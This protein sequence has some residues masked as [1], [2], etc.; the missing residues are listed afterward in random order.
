MPSD[1]GLVGPLLAWYGQILGAHFYAVNGRFMSR[2]HR[3]MCECETRPGGH[4]YGG[5]MGAD[6]TLNH[7]CLLNKDIHLFLS[8][9]NLA[10]QRSS[11]TDVH[12][13]LIFD[14]IFSLTP[15]LSGGRRIK[16]ENVCPWTKSNYAAEVD[17]DNAR[18]TRFDLRS[19][20][21]YRRRR[22]LLL[23]KRFSRSR[24]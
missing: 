2:L 16:H 23:A 15:L 13:H 17:H 9:P 1:T 7:M 8:V 19:W 6:G 14:Q 20:L 24:R 3:Y 4:P 22:R 10:H 5:S 21:P 18:A 11:R 12:P